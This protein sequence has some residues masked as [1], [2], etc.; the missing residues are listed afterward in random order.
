MSPIEKAIWL[1]VIVTCL[2]GGLAA[3]VWYARR[4][5]ARRDAPVVASDNEA[6]LLDFVPGDPYDGLPHVWT[7]A[8]GYRVYTNLPI[9]RKTLRRVEFANGGILTSM[10]NMS[11]VRV[12]QNYGL[13]MMR[14]PNDDLFISLGSSSISNSQFDIK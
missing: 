6:V 3:A 2:V 11:R 13:V 8:N 4:W 12:R 1:A 9:S 10:G 14:E 5:K 7:F